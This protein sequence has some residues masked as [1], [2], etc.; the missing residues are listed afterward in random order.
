MD[1][2]FAN[3]RIRIVYNNII[4]HAV[5]RVFRPLRPDHAYI[6]YY[7]NKNTDA[8][9]IH[10]ALIQISRFGNLLRPDTHLRHL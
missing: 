5:G 3:G 1:V 6:Q 8:D 9:I 2:I 4:R 7:A 10:R